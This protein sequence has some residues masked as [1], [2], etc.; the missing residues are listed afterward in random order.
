M[1]K[2]PRQALGTSSSPINPLLDVIS[3]VSNTIF[4]ATR[5]LID[6]Q[7][8][9]TKAVLGGAGR[10]AAGREEM[11]TNGE[12]ALASQREPA[13]GYDREDPDQL[14]DEHDEVDD[15]DDEVVD[16]ADEADDGAMDEADEADEAEDEAIDEA[17]EAEDEAID[18]ADEAED[19]AMVSNSIFETTWRLI[20][21]QQQLAKAVLGG[22]GQHT[23]DRGRD[24]DERR[25]P[26]RPDR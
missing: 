9:L 2:D 14:A 18:E 13:G 19:E 23:A 3:E 8:Q 12:D 24:A 25:R 22:A 21:A 15:T 26:Q 11:P 6:A 17:D 16:Q 5:R 20:D 10:H 1:T 7:Q 4:E